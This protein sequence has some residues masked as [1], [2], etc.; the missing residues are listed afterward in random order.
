VSTKS[1]VA[2]RPEN[3]ATRQPC[4]AKRVTTNVLNYGADELN[5]ATRRMQRLAEQFRI[6]EQ[7]AQLIADLAWGTASG[8]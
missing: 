2:L 3:E 6:P 4:Q 7:R 1:T 8:S 5:L